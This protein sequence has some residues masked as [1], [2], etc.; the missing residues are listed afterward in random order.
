MKKLFYKYT[1]ISLLIL[2]L[3]FIQKL[4]AYNDA[5][6]DPEILLFPRILINEVSFKDSQHDWIE[7][8]VVDDNNQGNGNSIEGLGLQDDSVFLVIEEEINVNTGDYILISFKEDIYETSKTDNVTQINIE[9]SGL[10]GTTEQ[11]ILLNNML[12]ILR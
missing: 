10:T 7:L 5:T 4:Y 3:S 8:F 2:Y 1:I 11:V 6:P 9:K 12:V